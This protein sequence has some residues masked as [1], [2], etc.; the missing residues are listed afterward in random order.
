[1]PLFCSVSSMLLYPG[2]HLRIS[3]ASFGRRDL[4][5]ELLRKCGP[6]PGSVPRSSCACDRHPEVVLIAHADVLPE[7]DGHRGDGDES[8]HADQK[9]FTEPC[10]KRCRKFI[11]SKGIPAQ[12]TAAIGAQRHIQRTHINSGTN[13][14]FDDLP[15]MHM[16]GNKVRQDAVLPKTLEMLHVKGG[17]EST[18]MPDQ[19][20]RTFGHPCGCP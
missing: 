10:G 6:H 12:R 9:V 7:D 4:A 15:L 8:A 16:G 20:S 2:A 13:Q 1:M 14:A 5:T 17:V 18:T 11:K 3:R 19:A